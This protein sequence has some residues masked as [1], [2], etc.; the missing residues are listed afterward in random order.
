MLSVRGLFNGALSNKILERLVLRVGTPV[1][2]QRLLDRYEQ[3]QWR[4]DKRITTILSFISTTN[5][6]TLR[7]VS[8]Y[9][10]A[11]GH[12]LLPDVVTDAVQYVTWKAAQSGS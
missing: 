9:L 10:M 2:V 6:D 12:W 7:C 11:V 1:S 8:I 3:K 5:V 4:L